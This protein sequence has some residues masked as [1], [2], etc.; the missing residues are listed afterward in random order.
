[1]RSDCKKCE[2][3]AKK[4][5]DPPYALVGML[6]NLAQRMRGYVTGAK[7]KWRPPYCTSDFAVLMGSG[8]TPEKMAS[9]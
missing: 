9:L 6:Y 8:M 3:R 5:W 7:S 2:E 1:L 4:P